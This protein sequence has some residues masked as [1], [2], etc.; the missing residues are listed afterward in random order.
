MLALPAEVPLDGGEF[1]TAAERAGQAA[2]LPAESG[3]RACR[4]DALVLLGRAGA[5]RAMRKGP[6]GPGR[7]P[8]VCTKL[9]VPGAPGVRALTAR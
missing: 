7:M 9:S 8:L 3:H 1:E 4:A 2:G 5:V 6:S